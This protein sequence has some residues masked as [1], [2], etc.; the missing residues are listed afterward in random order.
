VV[1]LTEKLLD[2]KILRMEKKGGTALLEPIDI[3]IRREIAGDRVATLRASGG[4]SGRP[5]PVRRLGTLLVS[6]G[7]RLAPPEIHDRPAVHVPS[8]RREAPADSG[9]SLVGCP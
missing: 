7:L 9:A 8:G 6:V 1:Y 4:G 5:E 2:V 3:D